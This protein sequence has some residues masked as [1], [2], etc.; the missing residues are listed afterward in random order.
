MASLTSFLKLRVADDLDDD[1]RFNLNR[2]DTLAQNGLFDATGNLT[3]RSISDIV[4]RPNNGSGGSFRSNHKL[5][6]FNINSTTLTLNDD[7]AFAGSWTLPGSKV[8]P[9][10]SSSS[11]SL[12]SSGGPLLTLAAAAGMAS[13][14]TYTFPVSDGT[15]GQVLST[16][17][18]GNLSFETVLTSGS[19]PSTLA[20]DWITA[21]GTTKTIVHNFNSTDIQV[22]VYDVDCQEFV[23]L[24]SVTFPNANT[25]SLTVSAPP[26]AGGFRVLLLEI[27]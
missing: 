2:I 26:T 21:D 19:I 1:S 14:Q 23:L 25:I 15:S 10:F 6:D 12:T 3:L 22:Q 27:L 7:I 13:Q 8:T 18:N 5:D 4:L 9:T 16:D 11:L 24:D 17:G 20:T